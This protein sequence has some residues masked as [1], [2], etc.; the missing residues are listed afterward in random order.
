V[1]PQIIDVA[2]TVT[3]GKMDE[4]LQE[5]MEKSLGKT[6]SKVHNNHIDV[7]SRFEGIMSSNSKY[8]FSKDCLVMLSEVAYLL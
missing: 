1:T 6:K 8:P 5:M 4:Y 3:E 7:H 2:N